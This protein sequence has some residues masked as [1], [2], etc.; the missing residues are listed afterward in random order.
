MENGSSHKIR[1][2]PEKTRTTAV[3]DQVKS[4]SGS[5]GLIFPEPGCNADHNILEHSERA[6]E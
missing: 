3:T 2:V 5:E 4:F 1:N 6:Q